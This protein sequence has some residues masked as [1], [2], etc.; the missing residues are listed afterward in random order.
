MNYEDACKVLELDRDHIEEDLKKQ[1]RL[2]ALQYHPDKN[3]SE[4][5][6]KKFQEIKE[7]YELL[8]NGRPDEDNINIDK[9]SYGGVL[10]VFLKKILANEK[11]NKVLFIIIQ[12]LSLMCEDTAL[13]TLGKLDR[14]MLLRTYD[15][16]KKYAKVLHFSEYF[17]ERVS[18]LVI[19]K[20]END[21][22]IILNPT[23][24]D[25]FENNL[26][27]LNLDGKMYIVPLWH[28]ELVY[29]HSGNDIYVICDHMIPDNVTFGPNNDLFLSL[30]IDLKTIWIERTHKFSIG[31]KE[32]EI[33]ADKLKLVP[34]QRIMLSYCGISRVNKWD[35]CN[36][37]NKGDIYIDITL[38]IV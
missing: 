25:L 2:M 27:K 1:Y 15:L 29:D 10:L 3:H 26:Y 37:T 11:C 9:S 8:L 32:F 31:K 18:D 16:L 34:Q 7:A 21:E 33:S 17:M 28:H 14:M 6:T 5:A 13:E 35:P 30:T 22:C 20:T 24:D 12:K 38:T 19:D 23:I 4:G 36:V